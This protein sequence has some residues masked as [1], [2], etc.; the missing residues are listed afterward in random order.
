MSTVEFRSLILALLAGTL[1]L[2]TGVFGVLVY[3]EMRALI[4][5]GFDGKLLALSGGAAGFIDGD[6]HRAFQRPRRIG[7]LA[8]DDERLLGCDLDGGTV[9][10]IDAEQGGALPVFDAPNGC[11]AAIPLADGAILVLGRDGELVR[12]AADGGEGR[13]HRA[14]TP[15]IGATRDG[16]NV[17]VWT[18]TAVHRWTEDGVGTEPLLDLPEPVRALVRGDTGWWALG[19]GGRLIRLDAEG[20]LLGT[21]PLTLSVDGEEVDAA[22]SVTS[23]A[24]FGT[25]FLA[26]AAALLRLE[27]DRG[28]LERI[29]DVDGYYSESHPFYQR[30][31]QVLIQLRA[32]AGLT[33]YYTQVYL[34]QRRIY[35]VLDGSEGDSHSPPGASDELPAATV[36][37]VERV[38]HLAEPYVSAIQQWEQWGLVKV[39]YSPIVDRDGHVVAMAGADVDITIIRTKTRQAL[40]VVIL[41]GL[42]SFLI[43]LWVSL[44][45]ARALTRP[46]A[47]LKDAALWIAAGYYDTPV[48]QPTVTE[49]RGIA[50]NLATLG[51][52]LADAERRAREQQELLAEERRRGQL[53]A[54]TEDRLRQYAGTPSWATVWRQIAPGQLGRHGALW[55]GAQGVV[56]SLS[57]QVAKDSVDTA[58]RI[59]IW[60]QWA[61]R[62]LAATD[63]DEDAV[64][65]QLV[66]PFDAIERL[67]FWNA[68][69]RTV[70]Y[71]G[72]VPWPAL[73][74]TGQRFEAVSLCDT[75]R[76][77][78]PPGAALLIVGRSDAGVGLAPSGH[79][80][81]A[82]PLELVARLDPNEFGDLELW[83]WLGRDDLPLPAG[84]P[85]SRT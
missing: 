78:V 18:T 41:I 22:A 54:A 5:R 60:R 81:R 36:D 7:G 48:V 75:M 19:E 46:I 45:V 14:D 59:L 62:L 38:Q 33:Y 12:F 13:R 80:D 42:G 57:A 50:A 2:V 39:S 10:R 65:E 72:R 61:E 83:V 1:V 25:E 21:T 28:R 31:R 15:W 85:R 9:L 52:R 77:A 29:A 84:S 4:V 71:R 6:G 64:L 16:D 27:P 69:E 70:R 74:W 23:L 30:Y 24:R 66:R 82:S 67:V 63:L 56:W 58:A 79:A 49:L 8:G 51:K 35:Y 26:S 20:R 47:R 3:R 55:R 53:I 11:R 73:L 76:L 43:T 44:L 37:G 40:F 32:L 34:G 68:R 17:L